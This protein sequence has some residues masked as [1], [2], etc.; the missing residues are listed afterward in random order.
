LDAKRKAELLLYK[1]GYICAA[2]SERAAQHRLMKEESEARRIENEATYCVLVHSSSSKAIELTRQRAQQG[3]RSEAA[4]AYDALIRVAGDKNFVA[5]PLERV[6]LD[7]AGRSGLLRLREGSLFG[8]CDGI[9]VSK[10]SFGD[11]IQG[12]DLQV[13]DIIVLYQ[14]HCVHSIKDLNSAIS[15]NRGHAQADLQIIHQGQRE[16][17]PLPNGEIFS[18][19]CNF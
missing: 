5:N 15:K 10:G 1:D 17:R 18:E 9:L 13:G 12:L 2:L 11:R 4:E 8:G 3:T 6:L 19:A 16:Q 7:A 14:D